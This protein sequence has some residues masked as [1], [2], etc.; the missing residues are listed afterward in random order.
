MAMGAKVAAW[1]RSQMPS[2]RT[3]HVEVVLS[4]AHAV[5]G[6]LAPQLALGS[7]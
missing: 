5:S 1:L 6:P 4:S 2:R 7:A 3:A